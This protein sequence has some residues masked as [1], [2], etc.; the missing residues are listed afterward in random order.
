M[1]DYQA[2]ADQIVK[3]IGGK[4]N[5]DQATHCVDKTALCAER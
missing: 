4:E 2:A 1:A 3:A 5:I